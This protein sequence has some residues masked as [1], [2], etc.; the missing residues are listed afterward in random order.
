MALNVQCKIFHWLSELKLIQTF[1]VD[2]QLL[3]T[4]QSRSAQIML[5]SDHV[6]P[7]KN[8]EQLKG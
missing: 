5:R 8:A 1:Y 4:T 7:I 2:Y 3:T 6:R